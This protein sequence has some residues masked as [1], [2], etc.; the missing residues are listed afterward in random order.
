MDKRSC[1]NLLKGI[2][3]EKIEQDKTYQIRQTERQ[4]GRNKLKQKHN[5]RLVQAEKI[6]VKTKLSS[7]RKLNNDSI[8]R[9]SNRGFSTDY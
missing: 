2:L 5:D 8:I 7:I 3:N 6:G 9:N 4:N 1:D